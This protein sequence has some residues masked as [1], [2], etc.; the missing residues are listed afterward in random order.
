VE[1]I[2]KQMVEMNEKIR[3]HRNKICNQKEGGL[4]YRIETRKREEKIRWQ[5]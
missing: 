4:V 5:S 3:F 1:N 2:T